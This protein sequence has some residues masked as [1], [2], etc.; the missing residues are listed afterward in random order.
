MGDMPSLS[1]VKGDTPGILN[2]SDDLVVFK[3]AVAPAQQPGH[4]GYLTFATLYAKNHKTADVHSETPSQTPLPEEQ[5]KPV[6]EAL[7]WWMVE[8]YEELSVCCLSGK[9]WF[10][11]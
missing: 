1:Y 8:H 2:E 4:T 11:F 10:L 9:Y 3:S 6:D 7:D 5:P